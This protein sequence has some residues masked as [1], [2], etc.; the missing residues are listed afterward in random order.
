V[1]GAVSVRPT[2]L[3]LKG[4]LLLAALELAFL[5]T[6]Y[7]NL[8]FL[9]ITFCCVLGVVGLVGAI[10][11]VRRIGVPSVVVPLAAAGATR[12]V[13]VTVALG[14]A[15]R[16][17]D[18]AFTLLSGR[19]R[20]ELGWLPVA[21]GSRS[22]RFELP[23]RSRGVFTASTLLVQ[24]RHPF[25]LFQATRRVPIAVEIV[26]HP[27]PARAGDASGAEDPAGE[28]ALAGA[29][30]PQVAGLREFRGGDS[31]TMVHWK[32]TARRGSPIVK[33]RE[34]EGDA[35][36]DLVIDRRCDGEAL[37][38]ALATATAFVLAAR[39]GGSTVQLRSQDVAIDVRATG[40][41]ARTALR[42]LAAATTLPADAP[43]PPRP[44]AG[45][46]VLPASIA[47][48]APRSTR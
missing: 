15:A 20:V 43:E 22:H 32:A 25:G 7:S 3:G 28:L 11:N 31:V 44:R 29:A 5:A 26:T 33:E 41:T 21:E 40:D 10:R 35:H 6:S 23:G 47:T 14:G 42:W 46:I 37:E 16:R 9:L 38:D 39:A 2:E 12:D 36:A 48:R 27:D 19:D 18:L 1:S 8:F 30:S 34:P 45:S 13:D 24:T 4:L 17:F